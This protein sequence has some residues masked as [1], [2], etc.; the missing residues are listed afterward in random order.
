MH[1]Y[2][3]KFGDVMFEA[4]FDKLDSPT[5]ALGVIRVY[6]IEEPLR[7]LAKHISKESIPFEFRT[8]GKG[9]LDIHVSD[10]WQE[11]TWAAPVLTNIVVILCRALKSVGIVP[12]VS[13]I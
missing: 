1:R 12:Q 11:E 8:Q 6:P 3:E 4:E 5:I 10:A 13:K 7:S 2:H 9:K